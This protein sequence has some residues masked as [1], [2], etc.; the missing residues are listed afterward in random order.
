MG[1]ILEMHAQVCWKLGSAALEEVAADSF[2]EAAV[3]DN[4]LETPVQDSA[5]VVVGNPELLPPKNA[6]PAAHPAPYPH[7][8]TADS[9]AHPRQS[10]SHPAALLAEEVRCSAADSR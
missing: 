3:V 2:P 1:S 8:C 10:G 4:T 9:P 5:E 7:P 6:V